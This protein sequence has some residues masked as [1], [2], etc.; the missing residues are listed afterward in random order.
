MSR[1]A[2]VLAVMLLTP[3]LGAAQSIEGVW[4]MV[5]REIVGGDNQGV[6]SGDMIQPSLLIFTQ[7]HFAW[8]LDLADSPRVAIPEAT[9]AE[10][11]AIITPLSIAGGTYQFDGRELRYHREITMNPAGSLRDNQPLFRQ[12]EVLTANRLETSITN[13]ET[14][15]RSIFKYRRVE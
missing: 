15:V 2:I 12:V 9:D 11:V 4:R 5:E 1:S 3:V 7:G 6:E 8:L 10:I 14:G 13:P